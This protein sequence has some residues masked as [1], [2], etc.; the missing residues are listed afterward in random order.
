MQLTLTDHETHLLH[1]A[2]ESYLKE[3]RGEIVDT[4]NAGFRR[5]LREERD[6]LM[7]I[8]SRLEQSTTTA[9]SATAAARSTWTTKAT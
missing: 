7:E 4:D 1:H 2:L 8:C 5:D 6:A 9:P 3:L